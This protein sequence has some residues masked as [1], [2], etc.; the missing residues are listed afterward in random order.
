[1]AFTFQFSLPATYDAHYLALAER[2]NCEFWTAD[3][4]LFNAIK[5]ISITAQDDQNFYEH[6]E[7]LLRYVRAG[8]ATWAQ[9]DWLK[10]WGFLDKPQQPK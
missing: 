1:M 10:R 7:Q 4:R 5:G 6:K 3:T 8:T 9:K 2:E